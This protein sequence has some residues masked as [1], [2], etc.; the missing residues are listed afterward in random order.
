MLLYTYFF[1]MQIYFIEFCFYGFNNIHMSQNYTLHTHTV[2]FDGRDS[3]QAMVNRA[4][5]MG[6]KT[7]GISNHFIVNP[8][9]KKTVMYPYAVRGGYSNIY[10]SSFEEVLLRFVP[11]Y[12]EIT[13][14]Q[15]QN[16]DM[17][18]LRGME[19]DFFNDIKWLDGFENVM[20]ILKPDYTIGSAHFVEYGGTLLNTHDWKNADEST[21]DKLL[22]NYWIN[23]RK[24][25]ESGLFTWLAHLDLPKKVGLGREEKWAEFESRAV[26][27]AASSKTAI[28]INTSFYREYCYE[29]YPSKRI[30]EMAAQND[31]PVIISDDAHETK[32]IGR[33]FDE[34]RALIESLNLRTLKR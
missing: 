12:H 21:R 28:E 14:I 9:I 27:A 13:T 24:A 16:P 23:V 11:H 20:D 32:N 4:R 22:A 29:P 31:V 7:I 3:V 17:K 19:V 10:S 5:D 26:E 15:E 18:I 30:L 33:H 2:G 1:K 25:A 8:E 6:F 34:A